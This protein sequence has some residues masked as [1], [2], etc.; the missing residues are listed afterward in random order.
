MKKEQ[1]SDSLN[2]L[3]NAIIEET[4]EIRSHK[5]GRRESWGAWAAAAACLT[6]LAYAGIRVLPQQS[7]DIPPD[8]PENFADPTNI[9]TETPSHSTEIPDSSTDVPD[10]SSQASDIPLDL[11]LL[12]ISER[13]DDGMGYSAY[14]AYDISELVNGNPW[15]ETME[16][17][18]L[19]VYQNRLTFDNYF[20]AYGVDFDA[21]KEFLLEI[22]GRLGLDTSSLVITDNT[23]EQEWR[24]KDWKIYNEGDVPEEYYNP[25]K[26][27]VEA[28]G[29][30]IEVDQT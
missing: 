5:K 9:P 23:S 28:E 13:N 15:S 24:A 10:S 12:S 4:N 30:T 25:T 17:T 8:L 21:M 19:P 2:M 20:V 7:P 29:V 6:L 1:I 3:D 14:W 27:M 26:Y 18:T 11:P 16:L 22:A